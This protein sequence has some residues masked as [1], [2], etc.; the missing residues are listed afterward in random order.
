MWKSIKFSTAYLSSFPQPCGILL[1]IVDKVF[2]STARVFHN[3]VDYS[4]FVVYG[5]VWVRG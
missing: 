5:F 4:F 1:D 2:H 3:P